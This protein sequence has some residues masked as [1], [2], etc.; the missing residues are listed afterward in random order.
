L[1]EITAFLP[2]RKGSQRV[3]NKNIKDFSTI[4]GGLT[5]IKISQLLKSKKINKIIISTNDDEV[6]NIA[7]SFDSEK[8]VIDDRP[9]EL[10]SSNTSTDDLVRYVP[11]II[12]TGIVLWTHVT[13]PFVTD[14]IYDCMIEKYLKNID[15]FDS[16]M[17]V[18]KVQKFLWNEKG[19]INYDRSKEKWPRTQTIDPIYDINSGAFIANINIYKKLEDR[20]GNN[21]YLYAISD[22][23]AFDIDWADDFDIAEVLW[24]KYGKI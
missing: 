22:K 7:K 4:K 21:P 20:I 2:M 8:I 13:S 19:S 9:E 1:I 10:A 12:D 6:K 16:L 24:S 23:E 11:T 15:N 5:F 3:K 18:T 14:L 17:S